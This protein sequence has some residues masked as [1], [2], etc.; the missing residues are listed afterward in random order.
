[1]A[2]D[3][4]IFQ[5]YLQPI[6][7]VQDY[8][9]DMDTREQNALKLAAARLQN[10]SGQQ[11]FDDNQKFRQLAASN[12][13]DANAL[14][15]A[16]NS[17]GLWKQ[18]Q[19]MQR[20]QTDI[21][22]KRAETDMNKG[23]AAN[24]NSDS[25][26]TDLK[27]RIAK[28]DQAIKDI[29]A[30]SHPDEARA[31]LQAHIQSG[32]IDPVKGQAIM[33][34]IPQDPAQFP[35]WQLGMLKNIMAAKDQVAL[36]VPD[37]NTVANNNTSIKTT[38]MNN[39]TSVQTNA[40]T[41]ATSRANNAAN[42]S[43]DLTIAGF[44]KNGNPTADM[45]VTA[46]AIASGQLPPPSGMALTNPKNQR[47]LARVMEIN[48]QYDFTDV[49]A[50][51]QAASAFTSGNQGNA[52]RSFAVAGQHLDQLG[53]LVDALNNG[54]AQAVN[55]LGNAFASQTG[56][57]APTNF[58]AAKDVVSKEVMKAI[59]GGGGGVSE[60]EELAK[61]LAAANS[62][63]QLK[64]VISQYRNLMS[65]QHDALLAQRRAAG[66]SDS[67]LPNYSGSQA[68]A[69]VPPDIQALINKH[70]GK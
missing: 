41:N 49:T 34:S 9:N 42:I 65:A 55:K 13:G 70:G 15:K 3:A 12:S 36:Q 19:A 40:A 59:I 62:P 7:S 14:V 23:K 28:S 16:A 38:G 31:N 45:E 8:A 30:F 67:T 10:Q 57:P 47:I 24:Y 18:A 1:M 52:L 68:G 21:D 44:D 58:D 5:Q 60:R 39:A 61:S 35:A 50:K 48:P 2:A 32:D 64:G 20:A 17:A 4:G 53:E 51:K 63:A 27:T 69:S 11:E 43:K 37:A 66:L 33:S 56:N 46:K 22:A 6:R 54:N 26:A 29:S 25:A